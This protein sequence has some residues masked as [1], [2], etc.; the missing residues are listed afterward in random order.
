MAFGGAMFLR[1]RR[2]LGLQNMRPREP[3]EKPSDWKRRLMVALYH[4]INPV[5]RGSEAESM[6][7][8]R[9]RIDSDDYAVVQAG[10]RGCLEPSNITTVAFAVLSLAW[11]RGPMQMQIIF[12]VFF[13]VR[14][15]WHFFWRSNGRRRTGLLFGFGSIAV[16]FVSAVIR[17]GW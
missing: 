10:M 17:E 7:Y 2:D 5:D 15:V 12:L 9:E 8:R 1:R 13:L 16:H 11:V 14:M 3:G 4:S 6:R